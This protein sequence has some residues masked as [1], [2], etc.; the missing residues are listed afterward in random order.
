MD[1]WMHVAMMMTFEPTQSTGTCP[2]Y[3]CYCHIDYTV[4]CD[5]IGHVPVER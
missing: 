4:C 1:G 2:N 5:N 3:Y